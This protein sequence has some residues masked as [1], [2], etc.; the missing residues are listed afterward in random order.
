MSTGVSEKVKEQLAEK[1]KEIKQL[2]AI[3]N[4]RTEALEDKNEHLNQLTNHC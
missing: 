2:Q 1:S 3:I 4:E